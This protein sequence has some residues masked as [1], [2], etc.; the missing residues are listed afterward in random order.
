MRFVSY[1]LDRQ[2]ADGGQ[3]KIATINNKLSSI[4]VALERLGVT[5]DWPT[6]V[7]ASLANEL[8]VRKKAGKE[9]QVA[10]LPVL[11]RLIMDLELYLQQPELYDLDL[12]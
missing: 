12:T 9:K 8:S 11:P 7:S 6:S 1:L 4:K 10:K 3:L 5:Q 2:T